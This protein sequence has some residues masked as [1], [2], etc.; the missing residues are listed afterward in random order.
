MDFL[1]LIFIIMAIAFSG[2]EGRTCWLVRPRFSRWIYYDDYVSDGW[3]W[4]WNT[5]RD[6]STDDEI[7]ARYTSPHKENV[8]VVRSDD[9]I[10]VPD[11]HLQKLIENK[12]VEEAVKYRN[13]MSRIAEEINDDAA[14]RKYAIYGAKI[15]RLKQQLNI[16][17]KNYDRNRLKTWF[18]EELSKEPRF[19]KKKVPAAD[20]APPAVTT[21]AAGM[22]P[23]WRQTTGHTPSGLQPVQKSEFEELTVNPKSDKEKKKEFD[24]SQV[25]VPLPSL[26]PIPEPRSRDMS[27]SEP[28]PEPG[29]PEPPTPP[30]TEEKQEIKI[31]EDYV[32]P[33]PGPVTLGSET[34]TAKPFEPEA[35][36]EEEDED[37]IDPDEYT[38]MINL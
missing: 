21:A 13:E 19:T 6:L 15:A 34:G 37:K 12:N 9:P 20:I 22:P 29:P 31:P 8:V 28:L 4:G 35:K 3:T 26:P 25:S 32:P 2:H 10:A 33:P 16:D 7:R 23:I 11:Y 30:V 5:G 14:K 17:D 24:I 27:R 18:S 1:W 38:E 36:S